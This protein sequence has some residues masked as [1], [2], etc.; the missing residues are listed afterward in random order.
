MSQEQVSSEREN[1]AVKVSQGPL[2]REELYDLVW[3]EP[4]LRIGERLGV[5]SSYMARVCSDLRVPRPPRGYWAQLE[6]GKTPPAR[7][8]LPPSRPG[9]TTAWSLGAA[10]PSLPKAPKVDVSKVEGRGSPNKKADRSHELVLGAK[11][12]FL[13]T[14]K[15]DEG[16]LRPFKRVLVDLVTSER[17]L[18]AG[19]AAA[20][21]LFLALEAAGYRVTFAPPEAR[22]RRA[23]FEV[24][25][26]PNRNHYYRSMWAPDRITVVYIGQVPTGLTL[27]ETLEEVEVMYVNGTYIPVSELT[28]MQLR[29]YQGPMYWKH[30][31]SRPSGR[32]CLQAYCPN[33]M[34]KWSQQWRVE[35]AKEFSA[36]ASKVVRELEAAAPIVTALLKEAEDKAAAMRRQW[37]EESRR[38]REQEERARQVKLRLDAT[39]ELLASIEAWDRVRR[40]QNWLAL[41]EREALD[42]PADERAHLLDRL[43][44]AREL[45]GESDALAL[46]KKW[47]SPR[48]RQ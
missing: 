1:E 48:E 13:K 27:F 9:D 26:T 7:P 43:A 29:R 17:Q 33:S 20:N 6:F 10:L 47:K 36:I 18:D 16:L 46:L 32:F 22:M 30:H 14:R 15:S 40:V 2:T 3:K 25:E 45:I 4:M 21:E 19:L 38:Q 31:Q 12:H 11:P 39:T 23:E 41:V 35:S 24:R 5:S 44:Q 8:A 28:P 37:E 34:V 42:L